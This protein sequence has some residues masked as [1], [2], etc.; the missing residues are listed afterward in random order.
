MLPNLES[1]HRFL[2]SRRERLQRTVQITNSSFSISVVRYVA[3]DSSP[4]SNIIYS[5]MI[6]RLVAFA[7]LLGAVTGCAHTN[8][9]KEYTLNQQTVQF[10]YRVA[11]DAA[12]ADADTPNEGSN[13][14]VVAVLETIGDAVFSAKIA[15]RLDRL[16]A[17]DNLA[18]EI[19]EGMEESLVTY[20]S[21]VPVP[22]L[23]DNPSFIMETE[24]RKYSLSCSG[25]G[26]R[27]RIDANVRLID[28]KSGKIVWEDCEAESVALR[29]TSGAGW[30]PRPASTIV[31]MINCSE[32]LDMTDDQ[33]R[34]ALRNAA[35]DV[36]FELTETL[37]EDASDRD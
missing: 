20:L 18:H 37:R 12:V 36:A 19:S 8:N 33:L 10:K 16:G 5:I 11:G 23:A 31:G 6:L 1:D 21:A 26:V 14:V 32:L 27:A 9:L 3:P 25:D 24:L 35:R 15:Q 29:R 34:D 30:A 22:S 2:D 7:V 4:C 13:N 28:R 17:P